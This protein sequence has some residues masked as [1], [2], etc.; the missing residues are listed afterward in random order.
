MKI[1]EA[2]DMIYI[3]N[4]DDKDEYGR[5]KGY[6]Y[7]WW[8]RKFHATE[9]YIYDGHTVFYPSKRGD[10]KVLNNKPS[11]FRLFMSGERNDRAAAEI[12]LKRRES[13]IIEYPEQ[14]TPASLANFKSFKEWYIQSNN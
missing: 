7:T 4:R 11:W 9:G 14:M 13:E 6:Y 12:M 2:K 8:Q 3:E 1:L 5:V 10:H